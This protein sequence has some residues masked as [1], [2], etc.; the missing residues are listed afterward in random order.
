[1]KTMLIDLLDKF[2]KEFTYQD[3]K[4]VARCKWD[5]AKYG[6]TVETFSKHSKTA[7]GHSQ[8]SLPEY[9]SESHSDFPVWETTHQDPTVPH[10]S[11]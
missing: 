11:Q 7:E 5:H 6:S 10:E 4:E 8:T 1:M 2:R 9:C 3:L